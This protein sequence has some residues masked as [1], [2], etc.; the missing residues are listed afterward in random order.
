MRTSRGWARFMARDGFLPRQLT[1]R[2][3]RLVFS[4]G[5]MVLA[6]AASALMII[7]KAKTTA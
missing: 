2:G 5:I 6:V 4:W 3:S 7:F 1:F